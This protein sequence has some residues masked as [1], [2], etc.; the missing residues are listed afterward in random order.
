[1]AKKKKKKEKIKRHIIYMTQNRKLK[2]GQNV[3]R[4]QLKLLF[5]KKQASLRR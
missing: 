5:C 1:M 2:T 3:P 4:T